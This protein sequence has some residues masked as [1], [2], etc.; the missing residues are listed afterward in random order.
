MALECRG[1]VCGVG[2]GRAVFKEAVLRSW[3]CDKEGIPGEFGGG[4]GRDR[5][6]ETG[7]RNGSAMIPELGWRRF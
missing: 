7:S 1:G 2:E 3:G 5:R 6:E 4:L